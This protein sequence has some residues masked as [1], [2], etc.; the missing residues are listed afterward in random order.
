[1]TL[2]KSY[3]AF[4][5]LLLSKKGIIEDDQI[6]VAAFY[7]KSFAYLTGLVTANRNAGC[8]S[9]RSHIANRQEAWLYLNQSVCSGTITAIAMIGCD[10]PSQICKRLKI[11]KQLLQSGHL[12]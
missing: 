12:R 9:A 11:N 6:E 10:R 5:T 8:Y 4:R 2:N 7:L 1:M 3:D